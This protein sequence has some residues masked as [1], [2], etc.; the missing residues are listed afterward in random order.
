[1]PGL[2]HL[3]NSITGRN[4]FLYRRFGHMQT[5]GEGVSRAITWGA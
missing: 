1:M 3:L 4:L 2:V 5:R